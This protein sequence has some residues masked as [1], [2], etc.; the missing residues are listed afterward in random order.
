MSKRS[1]NGPS[2]YNR[3]PFRLSASFKPLFPSGSPSGNPGPSPMGRSPGPREPFCRFGCSLGLLFM[4]KA[5]FANSSERILGPLF[6]SSKSPFCSKLG[7]L[8]S[9]VPLLVEN[10]AT[11]LAKLPATPCNTPVTIPIQYHI[12]NTHCNTPNSIIM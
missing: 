1:Q 3:D 12:C 8:H 5:P 6:L 9:C 11:T 7:P 4:L 2:P 10:S